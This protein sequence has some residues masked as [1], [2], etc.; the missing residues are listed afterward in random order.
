MSWLLLHFLCYVIHG[1]L[2][3]ECGTLNEGSVLCKDLCSPKNKAEAVCGVGVGGVMVFMQTC[4]RLLTE[5][6][7]WA[8]ICS[9]GATG[10]FCLNAQQ[11]VQQAVLTVHLCP[12][13]AEVLNQ[14]GLLTVGQSDVS[15][16][17]QTPLLGC[18]RTFLAVAIFCFSQFTGLSYPK[19][20]FWRTAFL[21][22]LCWL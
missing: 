2:R 12:G 11:P 7:L 10:S 4:C 19:A 9:H 14:T 6:C 20:V 17:P 13:M 3:P 18:P 15:W 1:L 21:L 8:R 16:G 5:L 22:K